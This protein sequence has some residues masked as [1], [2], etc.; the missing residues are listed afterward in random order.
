MDL[1]I[2]THFSL[3]SVLW[4]DKTLVADTFCRQGEGV[5][6]KPLFF[7]VKKSDWLSE[8]YVDEVPQGRITNVAQELDTIA[9]CSRECDPRRYFSNITSALSRY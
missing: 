4:P 9:I 6:T 5:P 2:S 3:P 8:A 1:L 7:A